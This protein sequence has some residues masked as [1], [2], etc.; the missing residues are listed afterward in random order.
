MKKD[1][2]HSLWALFAKV[3]PIRSLG[4]VVFTSA[5][6]KCLLFKTLRAILVN[7]SVRKPKTKIV[8]SSTIFLEKKLYFKRKNGNCW[9]K[10][11]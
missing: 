4:L 6:I 2:F 8:S 3:S 9:T 5:Q 11:L 7:V 10:I 1:F